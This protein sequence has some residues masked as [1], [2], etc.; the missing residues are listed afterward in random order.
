MFGQFVELRARQDRDVERGAVLDCLLVCRNR[1][2]MSTDTPFVR[3]NSGSACVINA[4]MAPPLKILIV[5]TIA[6]VI[7]V[8]TTEKQR[9]AKR[10]PFD[11]PF[12]RPYSAAGNAAGSVAAS[13]LTAASFSRS[14]R[15]S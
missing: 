6:R 1:N 5:G 15:M 13:A 2:S 4:R 11:F 7:R 8:V 12:V 14:A 10:R 3:S 9:A